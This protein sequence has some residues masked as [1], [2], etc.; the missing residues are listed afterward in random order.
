LLSDAGLPCGALS[1]LHDPDGR[2]RE[3]LLRHRGVSLVVALGT[4]PPRVG[5]PERA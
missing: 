4:S 1:L 5:A 2:A 3:L